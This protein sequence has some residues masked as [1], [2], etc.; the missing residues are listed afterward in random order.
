MTKKILALALA[1]LLMLSA[2]SLSAF[3]TE[4]VET[5]AAVEEV[6]DTQLAPV[7]D[8]LAMGE[9]QDEESGMGAD[10]KIGRQLIIENLQAGLIRQ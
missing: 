4:A 1:A 8:V 5:T 7:I 9:K 3:A 10:G 6:K 2:L